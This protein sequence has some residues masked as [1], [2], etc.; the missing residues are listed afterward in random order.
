MV[1]VQCFLIGFVIPVA[2]IC[3]CYMRILLTMNQVH[4]RAHSR[5]FQSTLQSDKIAPSTTIS[6]RKRVTIL[7][8]VLIISF[9]FCWLPF[10]LWHIAK[11]TGVNV[12]RT[13]CSITTDL[14]FVLAYFNA[15]LNP[16]LYSFLS[17][18]FRNRFT[19]TRH[20]ICRKFL[21]RLQLIIPTTSCCY[22]FQEFFQ[23]ILRRIYYI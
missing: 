8:M 12:S 2:A 18:D 3:F 22:P 6:A 20:K 9:I 16:I 7:I 23:I 5:S 11:I 14:T 10:H 19:L 17:H 21:L 13:T 15:V 1:L 4:K